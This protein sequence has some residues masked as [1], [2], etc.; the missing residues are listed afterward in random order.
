MLL[1]RPVGLRLGSPCL[2][3]RLLTAASPHV[4]VQP[5]SDGWHDAMPSAEVLARLQLTPASWR[6]AAAAHAAARR[7]HG[8]ACAA[9][10]LS[11][12]DRHELEARFAVAWG[13]PFLKCPSCCLA[14]AL[15]ICA[16]VRALAP[17]PGWPLPRVRV[18]IHH[19]E[20]GRSS[21]TGALLGPALGAML[22][23]AGVREQEAR[24]ADE[25]AEAGSRA[26]VL[27]PGPD[28]VPISD[29]ARSLGAAGGAAALLVA[30]DGTWSG[31]RK[32]LGRLPAG[33]TR[34]ALPQPPPPAAASGASSASPGSPPQP[35]ASH[36]LLRP[37]R[38]YGGDAADRV[39]TFEAVVAAVRC[40][41]CVDDDQR[42]RLLRG[43]LLKVDALLRFRSRRPV[44]GGGEGDE[45]GRVEHEEAG[46]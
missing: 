37:V 18:L 24:L 26:A 4:L 35:T 30:V 22:A 13:K 19:D 1:G 14:P 32:L 11:G 40:L 3:R 25:V 42:A 6:V 8:L 43:L 36:S 9:P 31:A 46:S 27:W 44:Y 12:E 20:C 15:C 17:P 5:S 34:V 45:A 23:V 38:K 39:C 10:G 28:A 33:V 41:G 29:F 7:R 16:A 21:N 2:C